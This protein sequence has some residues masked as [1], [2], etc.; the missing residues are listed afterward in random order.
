MVWDSGTGLRSAIVNALG[1]YTSYSYNTR[2]QVAT[3]TNPLGLVTTYGYDSFG[4]LS[5]VQSPLGQVTTLG[6]NGYEQQITI[7]DPLGHVSTTVYDPDE[8]AAGV[9]G[10]GDPVAASFQDTGAMP[11]MVVGVGQ[12]VQDRIVALQ[13]IELA[14]STGRIVGEAGVRRVGQRLY[15]LAVV[16]IV[17]EGGQLSLRVQQMVEP[18]QLVVAV[19]ERAG[20]GIGQRRTQAPWVVLVTDARNWVAGASR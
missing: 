19:G 1:Q 7:Q 20:V 12:A 14:D 18:P 15:F 2:N 6:Y 4:N 8:P 13:V 5:T 3:I 10:P 17:A 11:R 9:V 16:G